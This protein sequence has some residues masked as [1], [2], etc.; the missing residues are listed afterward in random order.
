LGKANKAGS[1][2][3][4]S[5]VQI[6]AVAAV[7]AIIGV[8][9]IYLHPSQP[10]NSASQ[11][12]FGSSWHYI[13][14]TT[15]YSNDICGDS[16]L[17]IMCVTLSVTSAMIEQ[18]SNGTVIAYVGHPPTEITNNMTHTQTYSVV[19]IDNSTHC[20]APKVFDRP[21]CPQVIN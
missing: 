12:Q 19:V 14:N 5:I 9:Y 15:E 8:S 4:V 13:G 1:L 17:P 2:S 10:A 7:V 20:V 11:V 3:A 6:L 16:G 18:W 21:G